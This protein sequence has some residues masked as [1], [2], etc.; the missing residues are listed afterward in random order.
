M[1]QKISVVINTLNDEKLIERAIKSVKWADEIVV[2]DMQSE[3]KT[4][5]LAK[6]LGAKVYSNKRLEYVELVRNSAISEAAY[7]WVLIL[8]PDEEIPQLL[9]ER[10]IEIANKF[11]QIDYVR[12]PRKNIIF[13]HWMQ[14]AMWWPD[15]NVRFFKKD[16]VSW[17][18]EIHRPPHTVGTGLDLE[19]DE[20]WAIVHHHYNSVNQFLERMM[21]Y[22]KIQ[23]EELIDQGYKFDWK[24]LIKKP[25]GEFLSRFFANK[26]YNDGL[27]GLVLSLLQSFSFLVVYLRVW[28]QE[29]FRSQD[30]KFDEIKNL[31]QDLG[32]ELNYWIKFGNLSS[33]PFKRL[34]QKAR[35]R[36]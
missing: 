18:N 31:S 5:A 29:K 17:G 13:D 27:H 26:G 28:E 14:A 8:D 12:I 35:N 6:K 32:K 11:K 33:N 2:Y 10:L 1:S 20:K 22:T 9:G 7:D 24:D 19:I 4:V 3:D 15:L 30:I 36:L 34:I 16:K 21:R 23:A 25:L